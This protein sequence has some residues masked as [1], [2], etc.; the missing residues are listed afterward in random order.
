MNKEEAAN[1]LGCSVRALER[2]TQ[3]GRIAA[4]YVK[5]KTRPTVEYREEDLRTFKIELDAELYP[6][7]PA[8]EKQVSDNGANLAH[9]PAALATLG[10]IAPQS[11]VREFV[12]MIVRESVKES[13]SA[14]LEVTAGAKIAPSAVPI[15]EKL[16]LSLKEAAALA[17]ISRDRLLTAIEAGGLKASKDTLGRGW[18]VKRDDLDAYVKK[19]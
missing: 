15:S 17:G 13:V 7:R 3:K 4:A 12:G 5:G 8:V 11:D 6:Q 2:Y 1:Y 9:N 10:N 19:L 18:R 14:A 16:M